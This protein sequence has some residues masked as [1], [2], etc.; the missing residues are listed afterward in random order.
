MEHECVLDVSELEPPEPLEKALD[1]IETLASGQYIRMLHNREPFP[2]YNILETSGFKYCV[3]EGVEALYEIFIWRRGD[4][5]AEAAAHS[6][7]G[8]QGH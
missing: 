4:E 5:T 3:Q 6:A 1:A 7:M 2:L 8:T